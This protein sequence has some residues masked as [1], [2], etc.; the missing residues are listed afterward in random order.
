ME[1]LAKG[2]GLFVT[3]SCLSIGC[4]VG[5]F[6]YPLQKLEVWRQTELGQFGLPYER[7][8][9]I[10][11]SDRN[12][13]YGFS[14]ESAQLIAQIYE[15]YKLQKIFLLVIAGMTA[16]CALNLGTETVNN[17]EI[18]HEAESIKAQGRKELIIEGIKHRLAMASKSQRLLFMD[19]MRSLIEEFGSPEGEILEADEVNSTDKFVN[20]S[21]L[22]GEGHSVDVVVAQTWGYKS[23]TSQHTEMKQKFLAW[24]SD[25]SDQLTEASCQTAVSDESFRA[26]F[27]ESMDRTSWKAVC[28][29]LGEGLTRSDIIRDVLGCSESQTDVGNA[30]FDFLKSRFLDA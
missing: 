4:L 8:F 29:A 12:N 1:R 7:T 25:D 19:E 26:V 18:D 17:A 23:G 21:Y 27:P 14:K 22:L 20:A 2:K 28:K 15:D 10:T 6:G 13:P 3:L 5:A 24:Q 30:Y 16:S 9:V 11:E